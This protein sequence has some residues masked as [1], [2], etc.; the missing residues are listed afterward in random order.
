MEKPHLSLSEVERLT[1]DNI[2]QEE[3]GERFRLN[4]GAYPHNKGIKGDEGVFG[5]TVE[6]E[7]V[8]ASMLEK[9][10]FM[11]EN[12]E[13]LAK[14]SSRITNELSSV[15]KVLFNTADYDDKL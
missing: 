7:M 15:T 10:K 11:V 8:E 2:I 12:Q 1:G 4:Y 14:T 6:I 5:E 13:V 3:L 9:I